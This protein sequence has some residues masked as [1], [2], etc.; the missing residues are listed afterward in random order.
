MRAAREAEERAAYEAMKGLIT[1][2]GEGT[3]AAE[4][5]EVQLSDFI[6]FVNVCVLVSLGSPLLPFLVASTTHS[7]CCASSQTVLH[8]VRGCLFG[9]C[10]ACF[11]AAT[12][13]VT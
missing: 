13:G 11:I 6:D 4:D 3:Q 9:L 2:E 8:H 5:A 7:F 12:L 1:V 10:F